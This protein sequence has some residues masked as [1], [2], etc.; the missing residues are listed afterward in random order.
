M[1]SERTLKAKSLKVMEAEWRAKVHNL[2]TG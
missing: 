1:M 2:K